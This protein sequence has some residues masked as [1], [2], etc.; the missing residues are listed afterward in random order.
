MRPEREREASGAEQAGQRQNG[1]S[2]RAHRAVRLADRALQ[3]NWQP[4]RFGGAFAE[5]LVAALLAGDA[6]R[7]RF[8]RSC[9]R[10]GSCSDLDEITPQQRAELI[11][12][13]DAHDPRPSS[14]DGG[15][16]TDEATAVLRERDFDSLNAD[17]DVSL[18]L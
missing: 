15:N 16:R 1:D 2:V 9:W 3:G 6:R 13:L 14:F 5:P 12:D 8:A 11:P 18:E 4:G 10:C 17:L 7:D